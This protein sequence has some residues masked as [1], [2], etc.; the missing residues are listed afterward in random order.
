MQFLLIARDELT[1]QN[2]DAYSIRG[3]ISKDDGSSLGG[4]SSVHKIFDSPLS[5]RDLARMAL[6]L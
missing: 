5:A 1:R 4:D 2:D 6:A 3:S